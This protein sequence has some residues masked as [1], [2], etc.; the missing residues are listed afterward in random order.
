MKH[1]SRTRLQWAAVLSAAVLLGACSD[2]DDPVDAPAP[3]P[4]PAT[5]DVPASAQ[6]SPTAWT[7][8]VNSQ[9]KTETGRPLDVTGVVPPFS[10]SEAPLPI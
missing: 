8:F 9:A 6:A 2:N 10:E 5:G 7:T 3:A 4:P 1:S